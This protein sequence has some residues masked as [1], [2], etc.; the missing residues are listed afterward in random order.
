MNISPAQYEVLEKLSSIIHCTAYDDKK[1]D[2]CRAA[3]YDRRVDQIIDGI[4]HIAAE[5]TRS[6]E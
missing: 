2:T 6:E 1:H 3:T 5:A 4:V